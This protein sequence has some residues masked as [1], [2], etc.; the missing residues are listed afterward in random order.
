MPV[1]NMKF[2]Y[3]KNCADA[4][5]TT[6]YHI[7]ALIFLIFVSLVHNG[8]CVYELRKTSFYKKIHCV[9][10]S[11]IHHKTSTIMSY[12]L[13]NIHCVLVN[14]IGIVVKIRGLLIKIICVT[15]KTDGKDQPT[16]VS[17]YPKCRPL[18]ELHQ[19]SKI[20][21]GRSLWFLT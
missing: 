15:T 19:S 13:L 7:I 9:I 3:I 17:Q 6:N 10:R 18:N 20:S 2:K 16:R 1:F 21:I 5:F 4:L 14:D 8:S 11:I 12:I